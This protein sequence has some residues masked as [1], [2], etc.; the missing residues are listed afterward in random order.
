MDYAENHPIAIAA[1]ALVPSRSAALVHDLIIP[2]TSTSLN[3]DRPRGQGFQFERYIDANMGVCLSLAISMRHYWYLGETD[4]VPD[5]FFY[6]IETHETDASGMRESCSVGSRDKHVGQ[7]VIQANKSCQSHVELKA[8][9]CRWESP[10]VRRS[11]CVLQQS[12]SPATKLVQVTQS[13]SSWSKSIVLFR[14]SAIK[15]ISM[16]R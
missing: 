7:V 5:L 3:I 11:S 9:D 12:K 1:S 15:S 16:F 6:R 8:A 2:I 14:A 10:T 4:P 13:S